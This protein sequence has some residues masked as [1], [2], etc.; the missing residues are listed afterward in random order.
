MEWSEQGRSPG[1]TR[2]HTKAAVV[3]AGHGDLLTAGREFGGNS[4]ARVPGT[5][6]VMC[7]PAYADESVLTPRYLKVVFVDRVAQPTEQDLGFSGVEPPVQDRPAAEL[8]CRRARYLIEG[9][10]VAV[11]AVELSVSTCELESSTDGI[12]PIEHLLEFPLIHLFSGDHVNRQLPFKLQCSCK[13]GYLLCCQD[14]LS[15]GKQVAIPPVSSTLRGRFQ[16]FLIGISLEP[17][18]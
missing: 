15:D 4:A 6:A 12:T 3:T 9:M 2:V 1:H 13:H 16:V 11:G 7:S 5:R 17:S 8:A 18:P 14:N 10:Q